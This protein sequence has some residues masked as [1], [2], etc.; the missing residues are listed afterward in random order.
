MTI[1]EWIDRCERPVPP[2]LRR[3]LTAEG[4]VSVDALLHAAEAEARD[5]A[6]RSRRDREAAFTLLAADAYIT[7]ACLRVVRKDGDCRALR[8]ITG[9]VAGAGW[10]E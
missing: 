10:R 2:R 1:G 4:P 6:A 5:C 8:D 3:R 7:Y 9:R